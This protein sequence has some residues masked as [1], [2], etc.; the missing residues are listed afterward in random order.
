VNNLKE[1]KP[2]IFL[3]SGP[4]G[5]GKDSVIEEIRKLYKN[6]HFVIT[7]VTRDKR[8][9]EKDGVNHFFI[10]NEKFKSMIENDEF[11][12]WSKVYE[13]FYG[14][15]KSQIEIPINQ[16]NSVIL[17]VDV[18]GAQKIKQM[19]PD[20]I[21]IFIKPESLDFIDKNIRNRGENS[22]DEIKRRLDTAEKELSLSHH[23]DYII[24]NPEGNIKYV[25]ES[26][27][28]IINKNL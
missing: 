19:I 16:G 10:S 5:V 7:A 26:V 14:V 23:F 17:R 13:N 8:S 20:L 24:T 2:K 27:K 28:D 1:N 6:F 21:M 11:I 15:P 25:I 9:D 12:E 22:E 4:S 18:Q 3:I